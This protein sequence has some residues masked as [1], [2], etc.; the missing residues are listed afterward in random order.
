MIVVDPTA[1]VAIENAALVAPAATVT[2]AGT[3]ATA[4]L[5]L[6]SRITAPPVGAPADRETVPC[7]TAPTETLDA[8]NVT[9][10]TVGVDGDVGVVELLLHCTMD[11]IIALATIDNTPRLM[12]SSRIAGRQWRRQYSPIIA[13]QDE[14]HMDL[15]S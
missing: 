11:R 15:P 5:L 8:L 13:K 7:A 3:V 14:S 6:V 10:A 2:L 1:T 4:V 9:L 12:D